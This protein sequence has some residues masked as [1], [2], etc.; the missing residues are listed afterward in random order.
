MQNLS[1]V[2]I[3]IFLTTLLAG[4]A[5]LITDFEKIQSA[6]I[7]FNHWKLKR[8][9]VRDLKRALELA[10]YCPNKEDLM[11]IKT[12]LKDLANKLDTHIKSDIA[13]FADRI[14]YISKL[15]QKEG[16]FPLDER[17][18][19]ANQAFL[20]FSQGGNSDAGKSFKEAMT[21]PYIEGGPT[22]VFDFNKFMESGG[23]I[24]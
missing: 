5:K 14:Y 19:L 21:L 1:V 24:I 20:Y 8:K 15:K 4:L 13:N 3:A 16:Y 17:K 18:I 2:I 23:K 7:K 11:E 12:I 22:V 6:I 9:K 10:V